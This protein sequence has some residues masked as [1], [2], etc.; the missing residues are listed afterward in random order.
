MTL[1]PKK[2]S[3]G[4]ASRSLR[5]EWY[6]KKCPS[7][8]TSKSKSGMAS[9]VDCNRILEAESCCVLILICLRIITA[10]GKDSNSNP[11]TANKACQNAGGMAGAGM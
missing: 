1:F 7:R 8:S 9:S 4:A 6:L 5:E 3:A 10:P 11:L 2:T